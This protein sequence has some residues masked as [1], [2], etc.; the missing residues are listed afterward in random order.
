MSLD[1]S[2]PKEYSSPPLASNDHI[3]SSKP[4][5]NFALLFF[6]VSRMY[7]REVWSYGRWYGS[8]VR[9]TRPI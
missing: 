1:S 8:P 5:P 6:W 7:G 9:T 3:S 4:C 2:D